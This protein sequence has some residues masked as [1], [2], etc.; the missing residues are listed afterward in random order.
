MD[1]TRAP[2]IHAAELRKRRGHDDLPDIL[3]RTF[4]KEANLEVS[5]LGSLLGRS[6]GREKQGKN[7]GDAHHG[8]GLSNFVRV[9]PAE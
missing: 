6:Q 7:S 9:K 2:Q 8:D 5:T 1:L 4:G 3:R